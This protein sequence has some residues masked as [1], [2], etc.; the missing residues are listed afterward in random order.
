MYPE[1]SEETPVYKV[2]NTPRTI[3]VQ[4]EYIKYLFYL[5][6]EKPYHEISIQ[7]ICDRAN[8]S[9]RSF[10]R[11]FKNKDACLCALLDHVITRFY[12]Y[13]I[14]DEIKRDGYPEEML[15]FLRYHQD[16]RGFYDILLSNNLFE[17][18]V[19]RNL[20]F[21]M[22]N[23]PYSLQWFGIPEGPYCEDALAF[24]LHGVMALIKYWHLSGYE[25][26]IYEMCDSICQLIAGDWAVSMKKK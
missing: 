22:A 5:M 25:R 1:K 20:K 14:P 26:S 11:Y 6:E 4:H 13:K 9:R 3:K 2:C 17:L 23:R 7:N 21:A 12:I 19:D 18:L 16:R 15:A 8:G 10:Y 24:Y